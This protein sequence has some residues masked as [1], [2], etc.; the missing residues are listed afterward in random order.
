MLKERVIVNTNTINNQYYNNQTTSI[1]NASL[2]DV[3][4]WYTLVID[5]NIVAVNILDEKNH[6]QKKAKSI[7]IK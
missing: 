1:N 2:I 5:N 6:T 3:L 7:I 4:K